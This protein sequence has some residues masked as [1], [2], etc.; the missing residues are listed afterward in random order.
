MNLKCVCARVC[1]CMWGIFLLNM[2]SH[3]YNFNINMVCPEEALSSC[4][5]TVTT[6]RNE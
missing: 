1:V 3:E 6:G 5:L 2:S 4:C